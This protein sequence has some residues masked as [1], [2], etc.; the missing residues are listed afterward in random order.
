MLV[1]TLEVARDDPRLFDEVL[2]W[3]VVNESLVSTRRLRSLAV[4]EIDERLIDAALAF[5]ARH[6]PRARLGSRSPAVSRPRSLEPLFHSLSLPVVDADPAFSAEGFLR[7]LAEPGLKSR[8]PNLRAPIGLAF[9][10]RQLLGIGVRSEV[11]R[12]LLTIDAPW[13]SASV[14]A[15]SAAFSKRNVQETLTEL[16]LAGVVSIASAGTD[17]GYAL[18]REDWMT[19]LHLDRQAMPLHRDWPQLLG[20]LRTVLRGLRSIGN[21]ELSDYLTASRTREL[22]GDVAD[23]LRHAGLTVP[24]Q[25]TVSNAMEALEEVVG[26]ALHLLGPAAGEHAVPIAGA[27]TSITTP[28]DPEGGY[29]WQMAAASDHVIAE[30]PDRYASRSDAERAAR[31]FAKQAPSARIDVYREA[32]RRYRWRARGADGRVLAV[33]ADSFGSRETAQRAADHVRTARNAGERT[34]LAGFMT[35]QGPKT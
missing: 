27:Q 21:D 12:T 9:R 6:R 5:T 13:T 16:H 34:R 31:A 26:A 18:D 17:R 23:G 10:L 4:D 1:F 7:P 32:T 15:A 2:D 35:Q 24:Q 8:P 28:R 11:I 19:L 33:S 14:L 29:R 22:L 3:L 30:S 20:A 25:I